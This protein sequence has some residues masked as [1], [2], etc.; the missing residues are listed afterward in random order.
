MGWGL[1][2]LQY[3]EKM[4]QNLS[5][6]IKGPNQLDKSIHGFPSCP[7]VTPDKANYKILF[8]C[9]INTLVSTVNSLLTAT[10]VSKTLI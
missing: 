5:L 9:T 10:M 2:G 4:K 8:L 3:S 6:Y 1:I 7:P